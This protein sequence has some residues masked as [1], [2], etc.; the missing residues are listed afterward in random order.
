MSS[1]HFFRLGSINRAKGKTIL[2]ALCH[3]KRTLPP[4]PKFKQE[5]TCKNY[6]LHGFDT[7]EKLDDV[8]HAQMALAGI[9]KTRKN[10]VLAVEIIFSLP[11]TWHS[12]DNKQF[13]LDCFEWTKNIFSGEIIS[14]DVHLDEDAPHAHAL[15][16][17]LIEGKLQGNKMMG[18]TS[19]LRRYN[20]LFHREVGSRHGLAKPAS[21][22]LNQQGKHYLAVEVKKRLK[23][24]KYKESPIWTVIN[25]YIDSDPQ[26]FAQHLGIDATTQIKTVSKHY[27]VYRAKNAKHYPV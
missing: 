19:N 9:R 27:S 14:F 6:A 4:D 3:N 10:Q 25:D 15:I 1:S 13:F 20:D 23:N 18:N 24:D 16:L 8:A 11:S 12:R 17:P 2:A 26:K 7:P 22:R 21:N 5:L